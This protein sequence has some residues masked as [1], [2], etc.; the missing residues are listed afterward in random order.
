MRDGRRKRLGLQEG[1]EGTVGD[2]YLDRILT[3]AEAAGNPYTIA[4]DT[5]VNF[6]TRDFRNIADT[7]NYYYGGGFDT[8]QDDATPPSSGD[9]GSGGSGD[10]GT[11]GGTTPTT[12][13]ANTPEQQRLIDE[14]IGLQ[15]EPGSPVFAPGEEPVTQAEIDAF[16]QIP[17]NTDYRNQQLVNQGIGLRV[18]DR[19]PVFAPGEEPVTQAEIDAF[20]QT[21]QDYSVTGALG[22]DPLEKDD[23]LSGAVTQEDV[24]NPKGLLA[25]LGI[26]PDFDIKKALIETGVNLIAG[27][28][29]TLIAKALEA[30]LPEMDPRQKALREFYKIDDIGRVA[31]GEL[32]AGYNPVSGGGLYTLT[33]GRAGEEPTYGLQ[34]AYDDRI[35]DVTR[36]LQD[37]YDFTKEEIDQIKAGNITSDIIAKGYSDTMGKTTNNIQKLADLVSDKAKE[38]GRLDLFSGDIQ[39]SGDA[40]I[41]EKIAEADRLGISGDIGVEG[42]DT[43]RFDSEMLDTPDKLADIYLQSFDEDTFDDKIGSSKKFLPKQE[44]ETVD[45]FIARNGINPDYSGQIFGKIEPGGT[46]LEDDFESLVDQVDTPKQVESTTMSDIS[47]AE[48]PMQEFENL[49]NNVDDF[50][51]SIDLIESRTR[52]K[53][54]LDDLDEI[55]KGD[56]YIDYTEQEKADIAAG[57]KTPELGELIDFGLDSVLGDTTTNQTTKNIEEQAAAKQAA[58]IAAAEAAEKAQNQ[59]G[60]ADRDDSPAPSAPQ[61]ATE[62][63]SYSNEDSY[64]SAAY[65]FGADDTPNLGDTDTF[66]RETGSDNSSGST[67]GG[68]CFIMLESRYGDGTMD[69]VVRRYRDEKM[70]PKNRRGYY[71][72]AVVLVP[73]MRK[74]KVFKWIVTKTFADPLVS[75]GKWYYGENKHGWIFAPVKTAWLKIFDVVGTDT[76]FIR[77]NG[78]EV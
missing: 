53:E 16:N 51:E 39:E 37:K 25:K 5:D 8:A 50:G 34:E 74:S 23:V 75:Y 20:N 1:T 41:A 35:G 70:T 59:G 42:E 76:V 63:A 32:M 38:K 43:D 67:G 21:P 12:P 7:Y 66:N 26:S 47:L 31:E 52:G 13:N 27:V 78:E 2:T 62:T 55:G 33:G 3:D 9:G 54:Y 36:T 11:G 4:A 65:D 64:E 22:V 44:S 14:G 19:G 77:E 46:I 58:A 68:C 72:M 71:K 60:G 29:I 40:S 15:I 57:K 30:V 28:P 49:I 17:V 73:L 24:D 18:G 69:K 61:K 56:N 6:D 48:M 10:G 45:D